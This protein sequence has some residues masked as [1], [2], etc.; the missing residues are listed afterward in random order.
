MSGDWNGT[1]PFQSPSSLRGQGPSGAACVY[2]TL[3]STAFGAATLVFGKCPKIRVWQS[4]RPSAS[5]L[6]GAYPNANGRFRIL[7]LP[8]PGAPSGRRRPIP[9]SR[10]LAPC[11]R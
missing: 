5:P 2:F 3:I 4:R 9:A 10:A 11:L 7:E 8:L 1:L 6:R